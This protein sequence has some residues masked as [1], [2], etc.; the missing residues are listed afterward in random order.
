LPRLSESRIANFIEPFRVSPKRSISLKRDFDPAQTY[1]YD[2]ESGAGAQQVLQEGVQLLAEYQERLAASSTDAVL[3]ILQAM[4]AAGKD[5]TIRHVMSGVNPQGVS[6]HS[7]K[8]PSSE[9]LAHDYLWRYTGKLPSRGH[10]AIFNRSYYEEV[11][12]V[13]VHPELLDGQKI[14]RRIN[15]KLKLREIW[16]ERFEEINNFEWYLTN[17]G[18]HVVKIFLHLSSDAQRQRFLA[19]INEPE[20]NWKFTASDVR[21]RTYW[22]DYQE[23]FSEVL[24]N[25]STRWAPWYVVP[26]DNKWFTRLGAAGVI[27]NTLI[28]IDPKYPSVTA[29][30]L[31]SLKTARRQ[32][33][34]EAVAK[35]YARR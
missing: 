25:T 14:P 17:Q 27:A 7:F 28:H 9:E 31:E 15:G 26:A 1:G 2:K 20:K 33:E 12:V 34:K 4:D 18:I 5:G 22:D 11:L 16:G 21:E 24:S 10:I 6:V 29:Q 13:R 3:V 8:V 30:G 19:R 23:A 32:L 35:A